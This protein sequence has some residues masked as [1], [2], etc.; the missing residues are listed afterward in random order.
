MR[1]PRIGPVRRATL[2]LW[3]HMAAWF[4]VLLEVGFLASFLLSLPGEEAWWW[5]GWQRMGVLFLTGWILG[6]FLKL[7]MEPERRRLLLQRDLLKY[8]P[9]ERTKVAY[10]YAVCDFEEAL[11]RVA[12]TL[13]PNVHLFHDEK[14]RLRLCLEYGDETDARVAAEARRQERGFE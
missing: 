6:G 14:G 8:P 7:G 2:H 12:P 4:L 9:D 5:G 10:I 1:P 3:A 11:K 13:R